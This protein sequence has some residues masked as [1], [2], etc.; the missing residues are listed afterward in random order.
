MT[1]WFEVA[2]LAVFLWRKITVRHLWRK[3]LLAGRHHV[4]AIFTWSL[5]LMAGRSL[6]LLLAI[7]AI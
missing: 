6:E 7:V 2:A 5:V 1:G 4:R 3:V